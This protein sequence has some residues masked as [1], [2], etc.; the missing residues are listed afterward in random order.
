MECHLQLMIKN[1]W[2]TPEAAECTAESQGFVLQWGGHQV[3]SWTKVW[4]KRRELP[5]SA[6]GSHAKVESLLDDSIVAA[7]LQ[8]YL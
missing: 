4:L 7:E 2:S 3:C 1:G 6:R 8:T 5:Q